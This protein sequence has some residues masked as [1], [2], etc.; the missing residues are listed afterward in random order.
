M[1]FL[2][3]VNCG[4]AHGPAGRPRNRCFARHQRA[5]RCAF[6]GEG[7]LTPKVGTVG[8]LEEAFARIEAHD[9]AAYIEVMIPE[10]ESQPLPENIIDNAYKLHTPPVG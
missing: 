10:A 8:E 4:D 5:S 3:F 1:T 9:G 7:W 2:V 6:G